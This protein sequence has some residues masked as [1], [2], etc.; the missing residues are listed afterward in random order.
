MILG[1]CVVAELV[2][3]HGEKSLEEYMGSAIIG[4][5]KNTHI[6]NIVAGDGNTEAKKKQVRISG[7]Y[8]L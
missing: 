7:V 1:R 5:Y 4:N 6:Y 3:Q 2:K 8:A